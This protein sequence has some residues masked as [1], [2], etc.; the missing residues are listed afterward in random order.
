MKGKRNGEWAFLDWLRSRWSSPNRA[1]LVG[2]GDDCAVLRSPRSEK[3]IVTTDMLCEG[4]H[5]R[6]AELGPRLVGRKAIAVNLSD[7]AAMGGEP[8]AAFL[9]VA[10]PRGTRMKLARELYLAMESMAGS[11][12]CAI[13]GGDVV[14]HDA[15]LVI[16]VCMTG[17]ALKRVVPRSGAKPGDAVFVTGALGG[18][19]E[20]KHAR[21]TP[22]LDEGRALAVKFAAR[23]MIDV[24]D[25]LSSD[26]G[27]IADE[28]KAAIEI[29]ER[30]IPISAAARRLS[31]R[32]G[33]SPLAHA[34]S[35][36]EDYEL[37]FTLSASKARYLVARWPFKTSITRIGRVR[38]GRD[39]WIIQRDGKM[40]RLERTGYE[41]LR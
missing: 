19:I 11:H 33:A 9:C 1:V 22:R 36:G 13:A 35:D 30:L 32:D 3:I 12:G 8:L 15:G 39:T 17:R 18:S 40:R 31:R 37:A 24:S 27:H 29:E 7:I 14:S 38:E 16:S 10:F 26:L 5:F 23:S 41:H 4:T 6:L 28:S 20:G 25:G 21:F 2:P 34:L